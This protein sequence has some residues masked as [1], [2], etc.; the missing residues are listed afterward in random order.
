MTTLFWL[1]FLCGS[2]VYGARTGNDVLATLGALLTLG[3]M[4]RASRKR[5]PRKEAK[6]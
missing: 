6:P 5:T 2:L 3:A 4:D 1:G